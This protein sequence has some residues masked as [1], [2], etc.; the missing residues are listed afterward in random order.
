M[1]GISTFY[2]AEAATVPDLNPALRTMFNSWA[3]VVPGGFTWQFPA[4]CDIINS[5]TGALVGT[6]TP[7]AQTPVASTGTGGYEA[8]C[9]AQVAWKTSGIVGGR[10]TVGRTYIVPIT[11][12]NGTTSGVISSGCQSTIQNAAN[13]FVSAVDHGIWSRPVVADPSHSPPIAGRGGAFNTVTAAQVNTKFVVL[14][15]RRD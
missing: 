13:T 9:G 7:A 5:D 10:R 3:S 8:P 11:A 15:S 2:T 1:P 4:S 14:R 6:F 12:G